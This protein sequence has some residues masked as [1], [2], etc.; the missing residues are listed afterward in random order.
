LSC[1]LLN[2]QHFAEDQAWNRPDEHCASVAYE[3]PS[4]C[5]F[6]HRERAQSR[7]RFASDYNGEATKEHIR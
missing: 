3:W 1:R 6:D 4:K 5:E 2:A 7:V